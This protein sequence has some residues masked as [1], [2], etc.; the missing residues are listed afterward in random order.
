MGSGESKLLQYANDRVHGSI[1]VVGHPGGEMKIP[2]VPSK[3]VLWVRA[4]RGAKPLM[5]LD[6]A[7]RL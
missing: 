7:Q 4:K 2:A 6:L 5:T 1:N 3:F